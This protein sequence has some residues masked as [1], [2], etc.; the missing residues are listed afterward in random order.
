[1]CPIR[2]CV[3]FILP[4]PAPITNPRFLS[5]AT[6]GA[7]L[8]PGGSA[9]QVTVGD[10]NFSTTGSVSE[11]PRSRISST[12]CQVRCAIAVCR[13][14]RASIPSASIRSSWR[15]SANSNESAGV[16]G[17]WLDAIDFSNSTKSK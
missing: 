14:H 3:S 15:S 10:R 11:M 2:I 12:H 1:M 5:S 7:E 8:A 9:M 4:Y 16:F 17:V 6:I 13:A